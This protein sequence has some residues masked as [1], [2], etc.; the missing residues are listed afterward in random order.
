VV[1]VCPIDLRPTTG[2][3]TDLEFFTTFGLV[4]LLFGVAYPRHRVI[5]LAAIVVGAAG[6]EAAQNLSTTRHGRIEDFE[7]KALAGALG[8]LSSM[9]LGNRT[10]K[11][12]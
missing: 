4:G 3:P 9:A 10:P 1:T 8:D 11:A 6:L 5:V 2:L 12:G 7:I